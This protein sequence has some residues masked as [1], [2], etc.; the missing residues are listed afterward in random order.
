MGG[1]LGDFAHCNQPMIVDKKDGILR[2]F[3]LAC[4]VIG[5]QSAA[6]AR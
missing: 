6:A 1:E 3:L 2:F 4:A 5:L